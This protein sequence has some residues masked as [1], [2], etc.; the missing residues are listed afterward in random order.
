MWESWRDAVDMIVANSRW[1]AARLA[2]D[3]IDVA[4]HVTYGVP[5][6]EPRPA[7]APVPTVAFVGRL[8]R[9]KGVDVLLRAMPM[10]RRAVPDAQLRIIGH[11]PELETLQALVRHLELDDAVTLH[12]FTP[13]HLINT[14]LADAW[15]QVVPSVYEEPFGVVTIEAMMRGTALVATNVGGPTEVVR[16]GE[17]G[18]LV[19]PA[20]AEALAEAIIRVLRDRGLA[21]RLGRNAYAIAREGFTEASSMDQMLSVYEAAMERFRSKQT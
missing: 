17:T 21:E 4:G 20:D 3:G 13:R 16:E 14:S 1:T 8:F 6:L 9:K 5:A 15:L 10:V 19:P 11:G 12:G 18:F 7:L 2:A